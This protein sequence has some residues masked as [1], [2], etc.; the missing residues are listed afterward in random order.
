[1]QVGVELVELAHFL[2][3]GVMGVVGEGDDAPDFLA[4][5]W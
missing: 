2:G 3:G 5:K 1:V 4:V